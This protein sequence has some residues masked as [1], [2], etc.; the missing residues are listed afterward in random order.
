MAMSIATQAEEEMSKQWSYEILYGDDRSDL[1][2]QIRQRDEEG[3]EVV[4][5]LGSLAVI[6]R[7]RA[8]DNGRSSDEGRRATCRRN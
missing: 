3:W 8:R 1:L 6:V 4:A 2:E 5:G 7:S